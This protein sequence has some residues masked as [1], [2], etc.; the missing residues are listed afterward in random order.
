MAI[1][2]GGIRNVIK[3]MQD[4]EPTD[5]NFGDLWAKETITDCV[6]S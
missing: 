4:I 2:Y 6:R 3:Y 1:V 5:Q